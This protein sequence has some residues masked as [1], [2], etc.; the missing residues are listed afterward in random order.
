[1]STPFTPPSPG[2]WELE[3][4]H[5]TRPL[6]VFAQGFYGPQMMRGFAD[7][8]R[9]YG[10]LLDHLEVAIINRFVYMAPR[11][12]GAPK[13]A[14]G[15]PPRPVFKLMTLLHPEM[16]RRIRRAEQVFADRTWR[17]DVARWHQQVK[18]AMATQ[19]RALREEDPNRATD[20]ELS[21]HVMRCVEFLK[22]AIYTHHR[23]NMCAVIPVGDFIVHVTDWT[24]ESP[25]AILQALRG[26][27]PAST[28]AAGEIEAIRVALERDPSARGV[29]ESRAPAAEV[30]ATLEQWPEPVGPAV[31]CYLDVVGLRVVGGY[32]VGEPHAREH[33]ELLVSVLR[34]ALGND[35]GPHQDERARLVDALRRK[36]PA[37][38]QTAFDAL[39]E[40]AALVYPIRDERM[41]HGD[42]LA[43]GMAR[44]AILAAGER[45]NGR[46]LVERPEH[47][48]DASPE[49]I[50]ALLH[51][52][53]GPPRSEIAERY[54]WRTETPLSSAPPRL[55]LPPSA[56]PPA[57]WL[58]P[59]AA[60]LQRAVDVVL[61]LMFEPRTSPRDEPS[62]KGFG[63]SPG[64]YEGPAR[65]IRRVDELT[66]V[67]SGDV[68]IAS[69]TGP[70]F[71]VVL[72]LLGALVTERGG[73][74]SHAAIVAREYG[75]PGV[76]GCL[77]VTQAVRSGNR[78]RVD[79]GTGEV[80]IV[81]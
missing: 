32:D 80:W 11:P 14:K 8:T 69:T 34:R 12:V 35:V 62:L 26:R 57:D 52:R 19:A 28:G 66:Q 53:P 22:T 63:V 37:A 1:M 77:G 16:R 64:I 6:T 81:R 67:Q 31:R 4:T 51:G 71:N 24:G 13:G 60:R 42:A 58:P 18:P 75:L 55:G 41:L 20:A 59:A 27:S 10:A 76:V 46:G 45:L 47:L 43:T 2:A 7:G 36:V 49:E 30:I 78:V 17:Q 33:P 68:L 23:F 56:P 3:Q 73:A 50:V 44:R 25:S 61:A 48:V 9:D 65:V 74:L 54:R 40:E 38:H 79:G 70:T 72:P 21:D 5:M 29:L 39:L 15:P